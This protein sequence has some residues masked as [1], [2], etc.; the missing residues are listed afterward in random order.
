MGFLKIN[1]EMQATWDLCWLNAKAK[2]D[3]RQFCADDKYLLVVLRI[4]PK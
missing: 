2:T 1:L 4:F 3:T